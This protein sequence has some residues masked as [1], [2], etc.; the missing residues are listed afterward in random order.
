MAL[1]HWPTH[2]GPP[3]SAS[4]SL[5]WSRRILVDEDPR[6]SFRTSEPG[7]WTGQSRKLG[8][9]ASGILSWWQLED[10]EL[11]FTVRALLEHDQRLANAMSV[12]TP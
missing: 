7:C 12:I 6:L 3:N 4:S 11:I 5:G 2:V 1:F 8:R 9:P 10:V